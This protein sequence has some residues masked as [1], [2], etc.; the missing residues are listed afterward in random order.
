MLSAAVSQLFPSSWLWTYPR[1]LAADIQ[2]GMGVAGTGVAVTIS[3]V[4]VG[5]TAAGV[6]GGGVGVPARKP[7][8]PTTITTNTA[9]T[10]IGKIL[11]WV[12]GFSVLPDRHCERLRKGFRVDFEL[13]IAASFRSSPARSFHV[14]ECFLLFNGR[15]SVGQKFRRDYIGTF[16]QGV[17]PA[18]I[19]GKRLD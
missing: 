19:A 12:P 16:R 17:N 18:A 5:A 6:D 14:G 9:V 3:G 7:S 11:D 13:R 2:S 4:A 1:M 10:A 15:C 8:T